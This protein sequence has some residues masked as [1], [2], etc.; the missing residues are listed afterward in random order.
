LPESMAAYV[1]LILPP[2]LRPL[3]E[4]LAVFVG[5]V[6]IYCSAKIYIFTGR[7]FWRGGRTYAKFGGTAAVLGAAT[8]LATA[9]LAE[10]VTGEPAM[11]SA[12]IAGAIL[13]TLGKLAYEANAMRTEGAVDAE[14]RQLHLST[15]LMLKHFGRVT[16]A[17]FA[18]AILGGV[19]LPLGVAVSA[20]GSWSAAV[21]AVAGLGCLVAGE[22]AE[23]VL[24]FGAVAPLRMPGG[25]KS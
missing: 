22:L 15:R 7:V 9:A 21:L 1:P 4:V 2:P 25:V 20:V 8:L 23:R 13:A 14:G 19:L 24:Y 12:A 17:R 16:T 10:A 18:F 6:G 5:V 11:L 3:A